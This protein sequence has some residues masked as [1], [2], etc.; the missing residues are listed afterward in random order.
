MVDFESNTQGSWYLPPWK[1]NFPFVK[2]TIRCYKTVT[3]GGI[4]GMWYLILVQFSVTVGTRGYISDTNSIS[5]IGK[6]KEE[7]LVDECD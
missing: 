4:L 2:L 7:I 3:V 6:R 5:K 1:V